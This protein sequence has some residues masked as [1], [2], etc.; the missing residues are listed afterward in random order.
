MKLI[1]PGRRPRVPGFSKHAS[2][3]Q[4]S[5]RTVRIDDRQ[6]AYSSRLASADTGFR[7][8]AQVLVA[9]I[10]ASST[11]FIGAST[12]M[13]AAEQS[14]S[15]LRNAVR[16]SAARLIWEGRQRLRS[17]STRSTL[18]SRASGRSVSAAWRIA[19]ATPL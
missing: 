10:N 1:G 14:A 7:P 9:R 6:V 18:Q 2:H 16:A 13:R 12:Q 8:M 4:P 17:R 19:S 11:G 5:A 15:P 3:C